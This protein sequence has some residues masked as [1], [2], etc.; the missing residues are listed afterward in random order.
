MG[1]PLLK[2]SVASPSPRRPASHPGPLHVISVVN[3]VAVGEAPLQVKSLADKVADGEALLRVLRIPLAVSLHQCSK[4]VILVQHLSEGQA[5]EAL[6]R[7]SGNIGRKSAFNCLLQTFPSEAS[8]FN[9]SHFL[10]CNIH[11]AK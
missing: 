10:S 7:I 11:L 9:H 1:V 8:Y 6:F 5:G 2:G 4:Y 3:I